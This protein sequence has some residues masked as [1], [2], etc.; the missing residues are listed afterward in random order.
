MVLEGFQFSAAQVLASAAIVFGAFVVRGT[1]GFGAG[2]VAIPLLVFIIPIHA[3]VPMMGLLAFILFIFLSIRDRHSVVWEE[4]KILIP[5]TLLGVVAGTLLFKNLDSAVLLKLLGIFIMAF[6]VY[7]LAVHY[8]GLPQV[9]CSR[10]WA[11]PVG[12]LGAA[13]DTMFGGGGGTLVVIYMHMRGIGTAQ[14][15]ATVAVLWFFE[16]IARLAGYAFA[17]YYTLSTLVFAVLML[18]LV[19]AGTYLGERIGNRISQETFSKVLAIMLLASG[20]TV[21][22]K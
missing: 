9:R 14:F 7:V 2:M 19:W 12:F 6:A 11:A 4:L 5:V 1:S 10:G 18:P 16:M 21:L 17:G 8:V 13:G 3:A 15:R 20:V 22:L